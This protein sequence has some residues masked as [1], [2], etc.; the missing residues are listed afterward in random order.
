MIIRS[1][2]ARIDELEPNWHALRAHHHSVTPHWGALRDPADS[3]ERR[4][5][6]YA[7]ILAEGGALFL[8]V[9]DE[10]IVGHAICETEQGGSPTWE[11]P[12]DFL[13]LVDL[14][15]LPEFRGRGVGD[16]LMAAVEAEGR[17]RGV[18][19]LDLAVVAPNEGA[20]RFYERHGFRADIVTYRK[21]LG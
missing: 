4:R 7:D 15:V 16:E 1:G 13:A 10:R 17:A 9:E 12:Q 6:N 14:V 3:W 20:R 18:A 2:A 21:P 19:A 11:W 5:K 8:A